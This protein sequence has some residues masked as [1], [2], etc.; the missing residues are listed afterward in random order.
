M[1][2]MHRV[3]FQN[4]FYYADGKAFIAFTFKEEAGEDD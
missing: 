2:W 3:E 1:D 4:K